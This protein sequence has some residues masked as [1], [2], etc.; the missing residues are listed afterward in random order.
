MALIHRGKLRH[1]AI[2][3]NLSDICL[4]Y[5]LATKQHKI[6]VY[7]SQNKAEM[8]SVGKIFYQLG[9]VLYTIAKS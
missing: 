1:F 8:V 6:H 9:I 3:L 2:Q 4:F 7:F 5:S